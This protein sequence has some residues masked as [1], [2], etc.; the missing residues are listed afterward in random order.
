M[1]KE[2][3]VP[4][5]TFLTLTSVLLLAIFLP[6]ISDWKLCEADRCT[7]QDWL[8]AT[9]GWAG[10]VAAAAAAYF[11]FHQL[12]EQRKQTAFLL[13]DGPATLEVNVFAIDTKRAVFR[14]INWNR[15]SFAVERVRIT[16]SKASVPEPKVL[17]WYSP[18]HE[19]GAKRHDATIVSG[20]WL[21]MVPAAEGW[22]DRQMSPSVFEFSLIFDLASEDF[23]DLVDGLPLSAT[24]DVIIQGIYED[25]RSQ[26][27]ELRIS[28]PVI[29]LLPNSAGRA[30]EERA[31]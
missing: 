24:A 9:A 3:F 29:N 25:G 12:E 4:V 15:R 5:L 18:R 19:K 23:T 30:F 13:G 8:S 14:I 11:V 10:F 6:G 26:R 31:D 21:A 22:L 7:L 1:G 2:F 16:C 20:G 17:R 27:S 28:G